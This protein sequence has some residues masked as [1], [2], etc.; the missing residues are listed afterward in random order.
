MKRLVSLVIAT[1]LL[2]SC[3]A[4]ALAGAQDFVLVNQTGVDIHQVYVSSHS[5]NDWGSDV[6]GRDI[7]PNGSSVTIVF[8]PGERAA[9]WDIRVEDRDGNY[10][11]WENFNLKQ[12][13]AITLLPDGQAEYR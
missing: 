5:D 11:E 4:V 3:S 10:L 7:L 2:V 9:Y 1:L 8:S 12:I 13:L 6:M